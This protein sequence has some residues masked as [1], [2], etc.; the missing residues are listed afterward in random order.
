MAGGRPTKYTIQLGEEIC[1]AIACSELGLVHLCDLNPH[2]PARSK[3]FEWRRR[4]AEFGDKY[5]K[6]K[7]EQ[8][9]VCVE[10]MH[11]LMNEPHRIIDP[12]TGYSKLDV[13]MLKLKLDHFKWHASKLQPKDYGDLKQMETINT[14]VDEDCKK[15][16]AEMDS[17]NKK[18]Y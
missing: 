1:S 16:Y 6:A 7:Q 4:H 10:Y 15:R 5:R 2:W 12:E 3:I 8:A 18:D 11:E 17:S 14:E 13:S 9:H